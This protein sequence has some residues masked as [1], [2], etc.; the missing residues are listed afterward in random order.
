MTP[1]LTGATR[2]PWR[3]QP[4]VHAAGG[5]LDGLAWAAGLDHV[6]AIEPALSSTDAEREQWNDANNTLA[7]RPGEVIAY[8]R[9]VAT[10]QIL[11]APGSPCTRS[12]RTSCP[13]VAW[14]RAA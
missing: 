13:A 4:R 5:L 6:R 3:Q 8:E 9:N 1:H 14:G 2:S 7:L 12:R 10:N 11:E